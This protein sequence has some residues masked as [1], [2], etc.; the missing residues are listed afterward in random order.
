MCQS[1]AFSA[2]GNCPQIYDF[3]CQTQQRPSVAR[4]PK[5]LYIYTDNV[6]FGFIANVLLFYR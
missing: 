3:E 2:S 6:S 5:L 4:Q 1:G